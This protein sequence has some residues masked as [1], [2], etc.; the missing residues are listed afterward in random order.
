M[1]TEEHKAIAH[2]AVEAFNQSDW[3]AVDQVFAAH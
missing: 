2:R 3:A 1:A